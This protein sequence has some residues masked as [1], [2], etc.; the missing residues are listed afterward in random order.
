MLEDLITAIEIY[1]SNDIKL[2]YQVLE[3]KDY[4]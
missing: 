2:E 4:D 1:S 3:Y